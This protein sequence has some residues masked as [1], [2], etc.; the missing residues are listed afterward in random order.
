MR[1]PDPRVKS[2]KMSE[3]SVLYLYLA[4]PTENSRG[5]NLPSALNLTRE[6][7][8]YVGDALRSLLG[9]EGKLAAPQE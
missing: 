6:Q 9:G 4:S 7:V 5:L 3:N 1:E 8:A 2:Q